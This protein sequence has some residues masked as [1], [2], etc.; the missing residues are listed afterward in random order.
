MVGLM[1]SAG[2][3]SLIGRKKSKGNRGQIDKLPIKIGNI[4]LNNMKNIEQ[5]DDRYGQADQP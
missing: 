5:D 1:Q 2:R 3:A 4:L